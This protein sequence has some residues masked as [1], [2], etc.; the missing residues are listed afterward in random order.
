MEY[1]GTH[2]NLIFVQIQ[3][4]GSFGNLR[5]NHIVFHG[6]CIKKQTKFRMYFHLNW[7]HAKYNLSYEKRNW[8][9]LN[10]F[11]PNAVAKLTTFFWVC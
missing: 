2:Y 6:L 10:Q 11:S 3:A 1:M 5:G 7:W 4:K 9:N 8:F